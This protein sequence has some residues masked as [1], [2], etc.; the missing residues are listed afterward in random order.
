MTDQLNGTRC[1]DFDAFRKADDAFHR[2]D[3]D[4]LRAALGNPDGF[5]NVRGPQGIGCCCLQYAIYHSPLAF[6][7]R[8]LELGANPNYDDLDG[9]PSLVAALSFAGDGSDRNRAEV[10]ALLQLL[11]SFGA[12]PNQRGVNDCTPLHYAAAADD[13]RSVEILLMHGADP[14]ARTR[15]DDQETPLESAERA[16]HLRAAAVLRR[17]LPPR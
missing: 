10:H 15:I 5:P 13:E 3:V 6:V 11:L 2:G 17:V 1:R 8:L 16:G 14:N 4:A 9:F 7:R 12:D